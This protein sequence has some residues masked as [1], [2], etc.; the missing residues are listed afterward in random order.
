MKQLI[1]GN[2][3]TKISATARLE[4]IREKV[5][6]L[7]MVFSEEKRAHRGQEFRDRVRCEALEKIG[8]KVSCKVYNFVLVNCICAVCSQMPRNLGIREIFLTWI[9]TCFSFF[10]SFHMI[11]YQAYTLDDKHT[12]DKVSSGRHCMANFADSRRM[13]KQM[14][15][16]WGNERGE[17]DHIILDYFFSPEGWARTRWTDGFYQKTLPMLVSADILKPNGRIYLPNLECVDGALECY[18]KELS[19]HYTWDYVRRPKD[20]PLFRATERVSEELMKCPDNLTNDSQML[21]LLNYSDTPFVVLKRVNRSYEKRDANGN[22][23]RKAASKFAPVLQYES[24]GTS[25]G[26]LSDSDTSQE[27]NTP[28]RRKRQRLSEVGDLTLSFLSSF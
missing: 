3:M 15:A 25:C 24:S 21:P 20:N 18:G 14:T 16:K 1:Y 8:Y 12:G 9:H 28:H 26:S 4:D 19:E 27:N 5:L 6:L 13:L 2:E 7:G 10:F 23:I 11:S 17:F 22:V